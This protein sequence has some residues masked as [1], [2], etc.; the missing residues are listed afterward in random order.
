M[1][2][3]RR[4][5]GAL[6]LD[7]SIYEEVEADRKANGQAAFAV[8]LSSVAA[9]IGSVGAGP[10]HVRGII[11]GTVG[12][13]VG[14]L[15]WAVLTYVIGT[16]LMPEPQT[17]ANLGE[18]LRTLAFAS[19]PGLL[20]VVG[21]APPLRGVVFVV[22]SLWMLGATV[23]AVRQALDY[24]STARAVGVCAVGWALSLAVA[25]AFAIVFATP[26]S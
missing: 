4:L 25:I 15:S 1:A 5:I 24:Q 8:L 17:R 18:L 7:E 14:W 12:G 9:G 6:R 10:L 3:L 20:R 26:V 11:V 22:T 16:R 19:S 21:A 23:V 13:F 2:F